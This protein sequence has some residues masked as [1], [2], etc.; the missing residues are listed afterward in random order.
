MQEKHCQSCGMPMTEELY[1]TK[2]DGS[3]NETYCEYCYENGAF[4]FDGTMEEMIE[5]CVPYMAT[6]ESGLSA[7]EA[8]AMLNEV[9]PTLERW[10][11]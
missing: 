5:M 11:A 7:D 4:T 8:R 6:E 9:L 10:S 1:G 2:A 3:K